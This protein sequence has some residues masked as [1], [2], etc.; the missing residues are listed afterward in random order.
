MILNSLV[1]PKFHSLP[2]PS[3]RQVAEDGLLWMLE[4]VLQEEWSPLAADAWTYIFSILTRAILQS[5]GQE[6]SLPAKG[7]LTWTG[8][9]WAM[10]AS[11]R[12]LKASSSKTNKKNMYFHK[13]KFFSSLEDL[14]RPCP[15]D[16]SEGTS[17]G[18]ILPPGE[19]LSS[20]PDQSK[21]AH[22]VKKP[23]IRSFSMR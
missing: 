11:L 9:R 23:L 4:K 19:A 14:T 21:C 20:T 12:S 3:I 1:C 17:D 22:S 13:K 7:D 5:G 16:D 18:D 15:V 2:L 6:R 10:Q 8:A